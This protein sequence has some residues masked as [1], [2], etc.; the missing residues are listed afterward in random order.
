VV[1]DIVAHFDRDSWARCW[2]QGLEQDLDPHW[3]SAA[4]AGEPKR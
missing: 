3:N 1:P 4:E 2:V